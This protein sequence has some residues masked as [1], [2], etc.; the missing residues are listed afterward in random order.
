MV[1]GKA[2][3][4]LMVTWSDLV[5]GSNPKIASQTE[6]GTF[7]FTGSLL[8]SIPGVGDLNTTTNGTAD[9]YID[10][11]SG[12][13]RLDIITAE[14]ELS[15]K[16]RPELSALRAPETSSFLLAG[17]L[18][19]LYS[20]NDDDGCIF[21]EFPSM[22]APAQ[23]FGCFE[24]L[25][26]SGK[27]FFKD[28]YT[29]KDESKEEKLGPLTLGGTYA[30]ALHIAKDGGIREVDFGGSLDVLKLPVF[31]Y[32]G[33]F[34]ATTTALSSPDP[35]MFEVPAS[36][37]TCNRKPV[38]LANFTKTEQAWL[39]CFDASSGDEFSTLLV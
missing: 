35:V 33:G 36:W 3:I 23:V 24:K 39:K 8:I 32:G 12:S 27:K 25:L 7:K 1:A 15:G 30:F 4:F 31:V 21:N 34:N 29:I 11:D 5:A 9:F 37:G 18:K 10:T 26:G 14:N 13:A 22:P 20:Y 6:K 38:C 17:K 2:M 19:R 16:P 28:V